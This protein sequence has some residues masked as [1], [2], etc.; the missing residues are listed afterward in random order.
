MNE[1]RT[2]KFVRVFSSTEF[3]GLELWRILR[4]E[5]HFK[6]NGLFVST[7]IKLSDEVFWK[8]EMQT[9]NHMAN[10]FRREH[11]D[12]AREHGHVVLQRR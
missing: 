8:D 5:G 12:Y 4:Q 1:I 9:I 7:D 11:L 2:E 10:R 6:P 3:P